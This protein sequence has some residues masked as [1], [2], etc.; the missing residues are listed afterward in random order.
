[1]RRLIIAVLASSAVVFSLVWVGHFARRWLDQR[2]HYT[3]NFVDLQCVSPPGMDGAAFLAEVQYCGTLPDQVNLLEPG[4]VNRL[5]AAFS[6]H[7]WVERVEGIV[8]R[9]PNGPEVRLVFR[10]PALAVGDRVVDRHG[11]LLPTGTPTEGLPVYPKRVPPPKG[12]AGTPWGD[13]EVEEA[14]RKAG[15]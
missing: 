13:V 1:M 9:G 8:L 4:L 2:Q 7:P 3:V 5:Q 11:V 14:A 12:R 15:G 6:L 10:T